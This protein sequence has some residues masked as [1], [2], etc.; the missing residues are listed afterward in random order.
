MVFAVTLWT[1]HAAGPYDLALRNDLV[2]RLEHA[3]FLAAAVASWWAILAAVQ[4]RGGPVGTAVLVLFALSVQGSV[5]GALLTFASAPWYP[6]YGDRAAAWGLSALEDQQLAGAIM[7]V[8]GGLGY[9]VAGLAAVALA[10]TR[11]SPAIRHD[12]SRA[13]QVGVGEVVASAT[14]ASDEDSTFFGLVER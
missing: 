12:V 10:I 1:W 8:P 2:H 5:L 4:R 6:S 9:L 14:N 13:R 7:W 11:P 3:M